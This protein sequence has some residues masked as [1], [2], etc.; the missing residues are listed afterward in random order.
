MISVDGSSI[1]PG[2]TF[3]NEPTSGFY[4][5]GA[6]TVGVVILGTQVLTI[7]SA[8]LIGSVQGAAPIGSVID[9]AGSSAPSQW[10]FCNGQAISRTTYSALFAVIGTTYGVGDGA[11]T[12]NLPDLRCTVTAGVDAMGGS[13]TRG[14]LTSTYFGTAPTTIGNNGGEQDIT[15][16]VPN[17]PAYTPTGSITNGAI[18][19]STTFL[20]SN[21]STQES[22]PQPGNVLLVDAGVIPITASQAASTFTGVAQGGTSTPFATIQP[23]MV[24]NKIIFAGA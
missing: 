18:T 19:V 7:T 9:F 20:G 24:I 21:G 8:G 17:L 10:Y 1:L 14:L 3:S 4:R 22:A 15:L 2:I 11:T 13:S 16:T 5:S 6:G 23:T 12:F